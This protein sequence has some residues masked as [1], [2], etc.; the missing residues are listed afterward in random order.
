[1]EAARAVQRQG[2]DG[3][4]PGLKVRGQRSA[5]QGHAFAPA[6]QADGNAFSHADGIRVRGKKG[7]HASVK[8]KVQLRG[9]TP[10][11]K[12]AHRAA[13]EVKFHVCCISQPA[14]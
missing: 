5:A 3:E 10:Q 9:A 4:I 6:P 7:I 12:V 1:M 13:Y 2:V 14:T 11:Q 8:G